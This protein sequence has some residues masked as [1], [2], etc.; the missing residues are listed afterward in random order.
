MSVRG[1]K[2]ILRGGNQLRR[3]PALREDETGGVVESQES[4][5]SA[6][7][8]KG[9]KKQLCHK[10]GKIKLIYSC[11]ARVLLCITEK[12]YKP[13]ARGGHLRMVTLTEGICGGETGQRQTYFP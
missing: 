12:N 2:R 10:K 6:P 3:D 11:Q 8:K 5:T 9:V 13:N 1:R 7:K 4:R